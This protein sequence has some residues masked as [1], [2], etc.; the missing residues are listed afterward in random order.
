MYRNFLKPF[1]DF[2]LALLIISIGWPFFVILALLI[3]IKIGKHVLFK[4][5]RPGKDGILFTIYKFRTMTDARG[6]DGELLPD[7]KRMTKFGSHLRKLS[8]DE[9]PEVINILKGEMSFIGPRPLLV[10]DYIFFD[11]NIRKRQSVRPGLSGWAQVCGRNNT[12]WEHKFC[13]DAEYL[14]KYSLVMD[15]KIFFMTIFKSFVT[16]ENINSEGMATAENYGDHLL[17]MG[18]IDK[19]AYDEGLFRSKQLIDEYNTKKN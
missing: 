13:K 3:R 10:K 17:K 15:A 11:E 8:F 12:S 9:L 2:S 19:V 16:K 7:E 14:L 6:S 1:L 18:I 5:I 4:Q